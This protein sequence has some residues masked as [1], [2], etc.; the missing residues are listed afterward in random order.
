MTA[1]DRT[2]RIARLTEAASARRTAAESRTR[3][4][5]IKLENAGEPIT[6]AS[7]ARAAAVST[8][9]LYQHTELRGV[10]EK[11][12]TSVVSR[13][14][15]DAEAASAASLRTKLQMALQRNRELAEEIVVLR[16]ENTAL[17]GR[18]LELGR[19]STTPSAPLHR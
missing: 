7:V 12:R 3:R 10:I 4:A 6:F 18:V 2:E 13:R 8:S 11:H 15:P 1:T 19:D 9:F 17:L 14:R 16:A 5:L